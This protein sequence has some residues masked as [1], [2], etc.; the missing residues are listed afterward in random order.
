MQL[1]RIVVAGATGR[2]GRTLIRAIGE[3]DDIALVGAL[4]SA[5]NANL[6]NDAGKVCGCERTDVPLSVDAAAALRNADVL[7]DFTGANASVELA[8]QAARAGVPDVTG[9]TG[10]S[11]EQDAAI[12]VSAQQTAIVKAG[13]MSLGVT[14]L[15]S[16]VK[17]A[18]KAL[19]DFDIEVL[20][21]HHRLKRDAPSGTALLLGEAA[22][23]GRDVTLSEHAVLAR[24]GD[25]GPRKDNAIGFASLRAG[26]VVGEHSVILAGAYERIELTHIAE[27]RTI[28]ANGALKAARWVQG[29]SPGLYSMPDV[30]GLNG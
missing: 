26:T 17:Q 8:Q 14:L 16:L 13:N 4:V 20:E 21:M 23:Q 27:D 18:T 15:A 22:A 19:P 29:K 25:V 6:G 30:L 7:I 9:T 12:A 5:A 3:R 1:L 10:F 2:M 11:P 28:F 24:S